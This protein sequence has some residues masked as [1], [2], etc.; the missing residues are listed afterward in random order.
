MGVDIDNLENVKDNIIYLNF[1]TL[2][3]D[4]NNFYINYIHYFN[5]K[6]NT[7]N[8]ILKCKSFNLYY[9]KLNEELK[10]IETEKINFIN[11]YKR[12]EYIKEDQ[13]ILININNSNKIKA[14]NGI[15]F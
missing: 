12:I 13:I 9:F 7:L 4:Y 6:Y 10:V 14:K 3:K 5:E 11:Q 15:Y 8:L 2:I 1:K